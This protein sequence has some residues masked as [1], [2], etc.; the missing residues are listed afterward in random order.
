M[1]SLSNREAGL[2]ELDEDPVRA[3][4]MHERDKRALGARARLLVHELRAARLELRQGC[5]DVVDAQRDVMQARAALLDVLRDGR[6]RRGRFQQLEARLPRRHEMHPHTLGGDLLGRFHFQAQRVAIERQRRV[7]ILHGDADVV[8]HRFHWRLAPV[9]ARAR[10]SFA[11][12]Y[13]SSS[14]AAMR[15]TIDD[16]SPGFIT[17]RSR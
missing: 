2:L 8:E 6:I 10:R 7:E 1:V 15:S 11:A 16:S 14:R 4:G 13:G 9:M 5:I 17:A 3:G 12:L